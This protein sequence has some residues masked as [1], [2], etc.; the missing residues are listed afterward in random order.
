MVQ[1]E[2]IEIVIG[3]DGEV[4]VQTKGIKGKKC[5]EYIRIVEKAVG[6]IKEQVL[7]SEYYEPEPDVELKPRIEDTKR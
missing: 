1:K 2:E 5:M 3:K 7:T 4:H 6:K